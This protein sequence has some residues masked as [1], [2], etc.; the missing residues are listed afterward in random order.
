MRTKGK[1]ASWND[2]KAYGFISPLAGGER[3]FVHIK[4]FANRTRRPVVGDIVTYGVATDRRGR[5]CAEGA[6]IAG[7]RKAV[8]PKWSSGAL[9]VF[10]AAGFL[11]VVGVGVLVSAVPAPLL[12]I[13]LG[14]S[15]ITFAAYALDKRA[16][17][18][19]SWRTSEGTLHLLALVGGWPGAVVAQS[20]L[21][22]KT[23]KQP[24]RA[25]FWV[26]VVMNCGAFGW[27]LTSEGTEAWRSVAAAV[28]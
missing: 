24:F 2:D 8:R 26:T 10:M 18:E 11:L 27:S 19:G 23:R 22:H 16:A 20:R 9:P 1:I 13:Y 17:A 14:V 5:P 21:R 4:A 25:V 3:V 15:A 28:A 7:V 12:L 6:T